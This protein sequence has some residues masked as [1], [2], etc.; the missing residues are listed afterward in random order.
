M[1]YDFGSTAVRILPDVSFECTS[2]VSRTQYKYTSNAF[3]TL[4]EQTRNLLRTSPN[5]NGMQVK[6]LEYTS[7]VLRMLHEY[8]NA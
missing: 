6:Y 2:N 8:P 5:S 7:N 4:Q 1:P 3:Q